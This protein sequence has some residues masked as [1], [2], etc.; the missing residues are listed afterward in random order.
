MPIVIDLIEHMCMCHA[1]ANHQ[2]NVTLAQ[3]TSTLQRKFTQHIDASALPVLLFTTVFT[4]CLKF[5][6]LK[7]KSA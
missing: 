6:G 5:V 7:K 3:A 4:M 1:L 2:Y